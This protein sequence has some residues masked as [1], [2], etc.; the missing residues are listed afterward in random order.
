MS[1]RTKAVDPTL[2]GAM[3]RSQ[4]EFF[5]GIAAQRA[6][7]HNRFAN[8]FAQRKDSMPHRVLAKKWET[9]LLICEKVLASD[10]AALRDDSTTVWQVHASA[11]VQV[12]E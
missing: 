1:P 2:T 5:A 10:G 6:A 3:L 9:L 4:W 12:P 8:T 11:P 7:E